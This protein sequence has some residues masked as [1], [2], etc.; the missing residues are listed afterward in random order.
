MPK[1]GMSKVL[2]AGWFAHLRLQGLFERLVEEVKDVAAPYDINISYELDDD[3]TWSL[4][5]VQ[6]AIASLGAVQA[7]WRPLRAGETRPRICEAS[8]KQ[9]AAFD[10][11]APVKLSRLLNEE[12]QTHQGSDCEDEAD[13]GT[14]VAEVVTI[15]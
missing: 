2:S 9:L 1:T 14:S 15:A 4:K 13:D 6:L 5:D 10:V 8:L 12:C 11:A 7:L 3:T